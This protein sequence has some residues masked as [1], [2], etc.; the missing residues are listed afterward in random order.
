MFNEWICIA[1]TYHCLLFSS[2]IDTP[3][4]KYTFGW[5][6][7]SLTSILICVNLIYIIGEIVK[8]A[9]LC[10]LR[11]GRLSYRYMSQDDSN[12]QKKTPLRQDDFDDTIKSSADKVDASIDMSSMTSP[13]VAKLPEHVRKVLHLAK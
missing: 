7:I 1:C 5:S 6:F 12:K 13:A 11:Y 2:F 10:C 8:Q 4:Q 9:Y 3:E